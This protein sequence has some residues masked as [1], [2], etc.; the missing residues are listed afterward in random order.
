LSLLPFS[1]LT[2]SFNEVDSRPLIYY[3][4]L[5]YILQHLAIS[6]G[7]VVSIAI[8]KY[9]IVKQ[10]KHP[11]AAFATGSPQ[12]LRYSVGLTL[13]IVVRLHSHSNPSGALSNGLEHVAGQTLF[14]QA[15]VVAAHYH[16]RA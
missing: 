3:I 5:H 9:V 8:D 6:L 10:T 14:P 7:V 1:P 15:T 2:N 13:R 12:R 16:L 4:I 11:V